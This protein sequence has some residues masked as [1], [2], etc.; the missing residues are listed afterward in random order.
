VITGRGERSGGVL[1]RSVP[2]WLEEPRLA[3]RVLGWAEAGRAHGGAGAL[4]LLLRRPSNG[5]SGAVRSPVGVR[6][7]HHR[8]Q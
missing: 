3:A 2:R 4:Y 8:R 7:S 6:F 1:R 5:Q